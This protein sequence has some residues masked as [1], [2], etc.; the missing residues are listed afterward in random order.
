MWLTQTK[1][2]RI[3]SQ[4]K[5]FEIKAFLLLYIPKPVEWWSKKCDRLKPQVKKKGPKRPVTAK[6]HN[7]HTHAVTHDPTKTQTPDPTTTHN[8]FKHKNHNNNQKPQ[9]KTPD[10]RQKQPKTTTKNTG[11]SQKPTPISDLRDPRH[12]PL[13][14]P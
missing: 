5:K 7:H 12:D 11:H 2:L 14:S 4:L 6:N 1:L 3:S 10:P 9:P 8:P 13:R